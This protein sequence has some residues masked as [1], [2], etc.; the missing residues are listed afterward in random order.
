MRNR[1]PLLALPLLV[2]LPVA[3]HKAE[4]TSYRVPK[5]KDPEM[6]AATAPA[7]PGAASTPGAAMADTPVPTA[8]GAGLVWTAPAHWQSKPTGSVRKGSYTVPGEGGA[9][10]DLSIT[11]FGGE[12]GGEVANVNRW[13]G[14]VSLPALSEADAQAAVTRL[15]ANGLAIAF[16]DMAGTGANA[17]RI[18]GA[19]VPA[20]AS[21]W[22]FKLSG[23]GVL[24]EKEKPAFLQFLQTVKPS[25]SAAP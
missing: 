16:V 1:C 11:A 3:C 15:T 17:Q 10:G 8:S 5:E 22:F 25:E 9:N 4:V 14:Q 23:P 18:L 13:R 21:T 6:P 20:G 7:T 2:L 24:V 12:T 19:I